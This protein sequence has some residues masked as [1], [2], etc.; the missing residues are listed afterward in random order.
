MQTITNKQI[1]QYTQSTQTNKHTQTQQQKQ[2]K[3]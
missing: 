1:H 3:T 2:T